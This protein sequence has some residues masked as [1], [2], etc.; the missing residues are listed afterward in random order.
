MSV[1]NTDAKMPTAVGI[2]RIR[3]LGMTLVTWV[4]E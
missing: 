2:P 1:S 4:A 3:M